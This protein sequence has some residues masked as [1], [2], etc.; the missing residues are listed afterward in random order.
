[1]IPAI[2]YMVA[3]YIITRM[4]SLLLGKKDGKESVVVLIFAVITVLVALFGIYVLF[5]GEIS[6][7]DLSNY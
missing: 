5:T 6:S 1:M 7:L 2:G 3:F 4:L